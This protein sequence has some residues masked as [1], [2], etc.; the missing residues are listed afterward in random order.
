MGYEQTALPWP[1][2]E[3]AF[4]EKG[5]LTAEEFYALAERL[6]GL[7]FTISQIT[8]YQ[9]LVK[10]KAKLQQIITDGGTL[11]DWRVWV[12]E[13]ALPWTEAYAQ[14]VHRMAV[15]GSYSTGRYMQMND[16]DVRAEFEYLMYDAIND[17]RTRPEHAAMDGKVWRRDE[18]PDEWWPPAGY[19][20]F[21]G[22]TIVEGRIGAAFRYRYSG[23]MI[24]LQR[25]GQP[26][27]VTLVTPNHPI[28]TPDGWVAAKDLQPGSEVL[29]GSPHR[30]PPVGI[31]QQHSPSRVDETFELA[32]KLGSATLAGSIPDDF[33]GDAFFGDSEIEIVRVPGVL[34]IGN[35]AEIGECLR[36]LCLTGSDHPRARHRDCVEARQ[37]RRAAAPSRGNADLAQ[38]ARNV[39]AGASQLYRDLGYG[40]ATLVEQARL[41]GGWQSPQFAVALVGGSSTVGKIQ[42]RPGAVIGDLLVTG[43]SDGGPAFDQPR[44]DRASRNSVLA[45]K[46]GDARASGI[47]I[48]EIVAIGRVPFAGHVFNLQTADEAYL[49]NG[50][51]AHNCRCEVRPL[52]DTMMDRLGYDTPDIERGVPV[53]EDGQPLH[54][55]PGFQSNQ[56]DIWTLEHL[57][58]SAL[59]GIKTEAGR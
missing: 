7:A 41:F 42:S 35:F 39:A 27:A 3:R 34:S 56:A 5:I 20:C 10:A 51:I 32:E 6:R 38:A 2:A 48:D 50:I 21:A 57:L 13:Q 18:F 31:D 36:D 25:L 53:D 54:A 17:L 49:A 26:D 14:L 28:A 43:R 37:R 46:L 16:P 23:E 29:T 58:E 22:S 11:A 12:D 9:A 33:H 59:R 55:D 4:V 40:L 15:L 19:N 30:W 1:E 52:N 47:E 8:S 24:E 45:G 44:R